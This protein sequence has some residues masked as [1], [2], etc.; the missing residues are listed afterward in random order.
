MLQFSPYF[1]TSIIDRKRWL[2]ESLA[3]PPG[4]ALGYIYYKENVAGVYNPKPSR[5]VLNVHKHFSQNQGDFC[6]FFIVYLRVL[7]CKA[8]TV[9]SLKL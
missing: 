6:R 4:C 5:P 1:F 8:K 7:L 2:S 9:V 3:S